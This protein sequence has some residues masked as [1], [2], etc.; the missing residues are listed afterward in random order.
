MSTITVKLSRGENTPWGFRLQ[1]GKDFS[2]P[3]SIGRVNPDSIAER[4]GLQTGD[5]IL[6]IMGRSTETM[7]HKEAQ[8]TIV[9]SGNLLEMIVERGKTRVWKPAVVPIGDIPAPSPQITAKPVTKTSLAANKQEVQHIGSKHNVSARPFSATMQDGTVKA[10]VHKQYNSPANIYSMDNIAETL[11]AQTEVLASG[12]KGINFLKEEQPINKESAVY[13][14]VHEDTGKES[15]TCERAFP[16]RHVEAPVTKPPSEKPPEQLNPN[17]CVECGKVIIGVFVRIKDKPLHPECFRCSTCGTSLKNIGYYNVNDKLYCDIHAKQASKM[18]HFTIPDFEPIT[19]GQM[20]STSAP[21]TVP[22]TAPTTPGTAAPMSPSTTF[23]TPFS[24]VQPKPPS[25]KPIS[26]AVP[27]VAS[28][29]QMKPA[30]PPVLAPTMKPVTPPV[31]AP[32][33]KPVT[34]PITHPQTAPLADAHKPL[35]SITSG[36]GSHPAPRRGRGQLRSQV[37]PGVRIPICAVCGSP[38]R[39]PFIVAIGKTWCP[40]HFL[41]SNNKCRRSLQDTGFVEEQQQLYCEHCYEA[42]FAPMCSKCGA[43]IKG[44]CLKALDKH[45]HPQCFVCANCHKPFGNSSFYMED[46]QPY[47]EKDWNELFTTKCIGCG[48]PIE[49]GDRWV[50]ALDNNYHSQCFKCTICHKNLEGQGFYARGGRPFCKA[51]A[52]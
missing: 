27:K 41:C 3:L 36:I 23:N 21:E 30:S 14:M 16:L 8:D 22:G 26:N 31:L 11:S 42:Y 4:A 1:G 9:K 43:R 29:T 40:D 17:Q 44:D 39:G 6:K 34:P 45:W 48:F 5:A 47:C 32:T 20:N 49:A 13:R 50:E 15:P 37:G 19:M 33:M 10:V 7:K 25:F 51:H 12:A 38:I 35:S 18:L 52:R 2:A 28:P 46:G 24:L